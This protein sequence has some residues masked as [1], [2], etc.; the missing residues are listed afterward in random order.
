MLKHE[1]LA[2]FKF[3]SIYFGSVALLI[4]ALGF[5]YFQEQ[6]KSI[7]EKEHFSMIEY[8]RQLKMNMH[9][10]S[11]HIKHRKVEIEIQDFNMD[12]FYIKE[13]QFE[14]YM[15]YSWEGGFLLVT[16]DKVHYEKK[17][18]EIKTYIMIVQVILLMLFA[19]I[20]F[21]LALKALKPMK[22]AIIKLDNF[23]KDLIHDLNTPITS[24]LLN[25]NLLEAKEKFKDIKALSRIKRSA[26][27]ISELH[28]NLTHL[29]YEETL[30]I[31]NE[32]IFEIVEEVVIT[33]RK[34]YKNLH[35]Y[36]EHCYFQAD[37]NPEAFRQVLSNLVSNACK[38]NKEN[39]YVKIYKKDDALCIEDEGVG[40]KNPENIFQRSYKEHGSGHG[41]GLDI[42]KRLCDAMNIDIRVTSEVE[43]GTLLC[44]K[45]H[46]TY[47]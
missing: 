22:N 45:F 25:I 41:I 7:L 27:D 28:T 21:F 46:E 15:P 24:I 4:L 34:I 17:L 33:H 47:S 18:F 36:V 32:S 43:K 39:G 8:T 16:K 23:S 19:G 37:I 3:F 30:I 38:Y 10:Q 6:K 14:K 29:L 40:I 13:H 35:F 9:P 44:L 12:N 42:A 1:K 31:S 20:S 2:F 26:E 5:F 11:E